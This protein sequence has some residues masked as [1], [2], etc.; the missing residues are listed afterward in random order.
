MLAMME[1]EELL[2]YSIDQSVRGIFY[3]HLG[4]VFR[5]DEDGPYAT[6]FFD[7]VVEDLSLS[8]FFHPCRRLICRKIHLCDWE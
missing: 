6:S 1:D 4:G 2:D 7:V 5:G 3:S 8:S